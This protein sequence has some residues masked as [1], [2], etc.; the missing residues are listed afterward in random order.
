MEIS[1]YYPNHNTILHI[2]TLAV[3]WSTS[4]V[5]YKI[6]YP[7]EIMLAPQSYLFFWKLCPHNSC[8]PTLYIHVVTGGGGMGQGEVTD[9]RLN[10]PPVFPVW[11]PLVDNKA[12]ILWLPCIKDHHY[13]HQAHILLLKEKKKTLPNI[14]TTVCI[15]LAKVNYTH[16]Y[17]IMWPTSLQAK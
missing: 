1:W 3:L 14:Y 12:H 13:H 17:H 4:Q 11:T 6:S 2:C 8:T 16:E 15:D 10:Q 9:F 5:G 7:S